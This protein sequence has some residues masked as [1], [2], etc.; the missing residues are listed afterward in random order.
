MQRMVTGSFFHESWTTGMSLYDKDECDIQ[1]LT[2]Q[3]AKKVAK[4]TYPI[5][6]Q[7][8]TCR[9]LVDKDVLPF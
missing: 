8:D 6:P 7:L 9:L 2:L 3:N 4:D 1:G 5:A